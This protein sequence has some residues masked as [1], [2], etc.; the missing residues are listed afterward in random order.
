MIARPLLFSAALVIF[1][2]SEGWATQMDRV[3]SVPL[4][5]NAAVVD[6]LRVRASGDMYL[7]SFRH[8]PLPPRVNTN[9]VL[10]E[11]EDRTLGSLFYTN[12]E[13]IFKSRDKSLGGMVIADP[14]KKL[15]VIFQHCCS[16]QQISVATYAGELPRGLAVRHIP[17][18]TFA[19]FSIGSHFG[20]VID[21][22]GEPLKKSAGGTTWHY[23]G[24]RPGATQ[25]CGRQWQLRFTHQRLS[26][27][28]ISEGC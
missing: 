5:N 8:I 10:S 19:G 7:D 15:V 22:F 27:I 16:I 11:S 17:S 25:T 21:H 26:A 24:P 28:T 14:A 9:M 20:D 1:S 2:A 13:T 18:L 23:Y 6:F 3:R 12:T 4:S